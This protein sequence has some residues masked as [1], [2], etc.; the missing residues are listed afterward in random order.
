ME[1]IK[2][3]KQLKRIPIDSIDISEFEGNLEDVM[4]RLSG[5]RD[6]QY[7]RIDII[8]CVDDGEDG[9]YCYIDIIGNRMETDEEFEKRKDEV[10]KKEL[11]KYIAQQGIKKQMGKFIISESKPLKSKPSANIKTQFRVEPYDPNKY[12]KIK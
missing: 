2:Y 6:K 5:F 4:E 1:E 11:Y 9:P 7:S 8:P 3:E 10:A 12:K